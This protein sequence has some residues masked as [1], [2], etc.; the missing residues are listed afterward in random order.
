LR[1]QGPIPFSVRGY[2][3]RGYARKRQTLKATIQ[4]YGARRPPCALLGGTA[5]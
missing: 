4:G 1:K 5:N 2:S 3:V